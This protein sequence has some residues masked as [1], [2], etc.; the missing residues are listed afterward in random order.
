MK[1]SLALL[2]LAAT[3]ALC[4]PTASP[5]ELAVIEECGELGVM[6][7]N[8]ADLPEGTDIS[9][10]RKCKKHPSELGI[11]S[12]QYNATI[13]ESDLT[14]AAKRGELIATDAELEKR[15]QCTTGGRGHGLDYDYGCDNGWCW[16]NCDGPFWQTGERKTW[17][18]LAYESGAGGWTPCG[19][20]QD[21]EWSYNNKAAKCGKGDCKACG[22]GC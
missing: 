5:A 19:R 11:T 2:S 4:S 1:F 18:W 9:T 17:C 13:E 3:R 12:P 14:S 6:E 8:Q 16:R 20:W 15:G 21:C 7:W 10:L 22:C